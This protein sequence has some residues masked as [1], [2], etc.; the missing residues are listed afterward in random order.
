MIRADDEAAGEGAP[1]SLSSAEAVAELRSS[2]A[3]VP[4]EC[5][6]EAFNLREPETFERFSPSE[7]SH[8][9][10]LIVEKLTNALDQVELRLLSEASARASAFFGALVEYDR[11]AKEVGEATS[12][13]STDQ[14]R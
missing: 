11:L 14:S 8:A 12:Q 6:E 1:P 10:P 7:A 5:F 9:S 3:A 13:V 2:L 4:A